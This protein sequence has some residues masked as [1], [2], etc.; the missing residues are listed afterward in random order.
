MNYLI[1]AAGVVLVSF[2]LINVFVSTLA[3]RGSRVFTQ[4][5]LHWV[6]KFFYWLA[7]GNGKKP[8]LNYAGLTTLG[9]F[10]IVWIFLFWSTGMFA[11][12]GS[13]IAIG[14]VV[15]Y[16]IKESIS[17]NSTQSSTILH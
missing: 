4:R 17:N 12:W 16:F 3:P 1:F 15:V 2:V 13:L 14:G 8:I 6:W 7:N 5:L 9:I 11:L 10:L